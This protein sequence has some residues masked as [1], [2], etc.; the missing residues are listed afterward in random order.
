MFPPGA[1]AAVKPG[2]RSSPPEHGWRQ[3]V[4]ASARPVLSSGA[5]STFAENAP[6]A[7]QAASAAARAPPTRGDAND[8]TP[9]PD[10]RTGRD[11]HHDNGLAPGASGAARHLVRP[12]TRS[13]HALHDGDVGA[14]L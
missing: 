4:A 3:F 14:V 13:R 2:R 10:R 1:S 8:P 7:R 9:A 5:G 6:L 11:R 12:P